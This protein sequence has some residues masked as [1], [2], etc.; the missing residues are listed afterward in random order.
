MEVCERGVTEGSITVV[1]NRSTLCGG[2]VKRADVSGVEK[3][4]V[5]ED[6][7]RCER[8]IFSRRVTVVDGDR[9]SVIDTRYI[10]DQRIVIGLGSASTGVAQIVHDDLD[11][12]WTIELDIRCEDHTVEETIDV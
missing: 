6:V 5:A 8:R 2:R 9:R 11:R 12:G 3:S 10:D 7:H 4:V 1:N